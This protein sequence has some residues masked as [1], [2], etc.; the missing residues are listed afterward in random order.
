MKFSYEGFDRSGAPVT[1]SVDASGPE[2]ATEALAR[3]G[4]FVTSIAAVAA[5]ARAT[6]R[7]PA[8]GERA[9]AFFRQLSI[10]IGTGTPLV[11][12]LTAM[13][14]QASGPWQA[15]LASMRQKVEEGS[16]LSD[17]LAAHPECFDPVTY[18]LVAAGE[19]GGEL[20]EM[21]RRLADLMR[22]QVR[23]RKTVRGAMAY[24]ALLLVIA[25]AVT[26]TM[27]CFVLP[28][29][30]ELFKSLGAPLPPTTKL[31]MQAGAFVRERW[32]VVLTVLAGVIIAAR[33][34]LSRGGGVEQI[35]RAALRTPKIGTVMRDFATA[36]LARVLGV[37]LNGRVGMLDALRLTRQSVG[38]PAFAELIARAE[39][40][41]TKGEAISAAFANSSI[42]TPAVCE[43]IRSGE[44]SG[45]LPE[46]MID[47]ADHLD[48]D[49]E[50]T[51]K[52]VTGLIEPA[53]L[54]VL[55]LVVGGMAVSLFLPLFD[56]TAAGGAR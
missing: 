5:A 16:Q 26:T 21:L 13:E 45:K 33:F 2:Q 56:L 28:R 7:V 30:E 35:S 25:L 9:A 40:A 24:P 38:H 15:V 27:V 48:E 49:N 11:D 44:R 8:A 23:V 36:R 37:L 12:A 55:G 22:R 17:A 41:V 4:I 1:A 3:Q 51:L 43:A 46:V 53:I 29:F 10:L 54:V 34:W 50:L 20:D 32:Y 6:G 14:R 47:L 19:S 18:S 42:I 31:L 52:T 39:D